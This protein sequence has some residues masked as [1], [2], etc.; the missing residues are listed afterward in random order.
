[1]SA[2]LCAKSNLQRKRRRKKTDANIY[3]FLCRL[4]WSSRS[5]S[6]DIVLLCQLM[7]NKCK[8]TGDRVNDGDIHTVKIKI[9][10][11]QKYKA[12]SAA[13][14]ESPSH[15]RG[16][17]AAGRVHEVRQVEALV[18][19]LEGKET[20][21]CFPQHNII[22]LKKK[23]FFPRPVLPWPRRRWPWAR[24]PQSCRSGS[25]GWTGNGSL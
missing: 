6:L 14:S 8:T 18:D 23:H 12:S 5:I 2:T 13:R 4:E 3:N 1:M 22:F 10:I 25:W 24:S 7:V 19:R 20:D 11:W 15:D 9:S 17:G 16:G 21:Y